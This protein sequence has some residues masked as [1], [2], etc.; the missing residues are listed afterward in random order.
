MGEAGASMFLVATS[1]RTAAGDQ[2]PPAEQ[3]VT[4]YNVPWSHYDVQVALRG[5]KALPRLSFLGGTLELMSPS[6]D[7]ERIKEYLGD[8][9][10]AYADERGVELS[11]YGSWTLKSASRESGLEP[12]QCFIFGLDQ[13]KPIPDLAIEVALT[14][15]GIDKLEIYRRL[16]V[17]E[18]WFWRGGRIEVY[19]LEDGRHRQ[20]E[21]SRLLPDL[22]L[23]WASSLLDQPTAQ[24]AVQALRQ[25]LRQSSS[26]P[27]PPASRSDGE[28]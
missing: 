26:S 2:P 1:L 19:V 20:Q 10:K 13:G 25:R 12:D 27:V 18:V 16:G 14:G 7:H 8:L 23:S 3:R 17:G 6:K 5:E 22:E 24:R 21:R 11:S 9:V 28:R 4:S 15:G